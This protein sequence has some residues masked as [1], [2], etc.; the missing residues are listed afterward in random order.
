M[1]STDSYPSDIAFDFRP[2][3]GKAVLATNRG[4]DGS[5]RRYG[6]LC[7]DGR[8]KMF[9]VTLEGDALHLQLCTPLVAAHVV[10]RLRLGLDHIHEISAFAYRLAL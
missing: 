4:N 8:G 5:A 3:G 1:E 6:H 9:D 10:T 7:V 2:L